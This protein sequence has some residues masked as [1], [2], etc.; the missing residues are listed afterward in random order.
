[1]LMALYQGCRLIGQEIMCKASLGLKDTCTCIHA[2]PH[3]WHWD[4]RREVWHQTLVH[5]AQALRG[6]LAAGALQQGL[7]EDM[8]EVA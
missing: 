2:V 7:R 1:M 3:A 5:C 6:D 4:G 8:A